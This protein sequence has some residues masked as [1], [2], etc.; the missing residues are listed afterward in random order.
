MSIDLGKPAD[1][2]HLHAI[3]MPGDLDFSMHLQ[4]GTWNNP[5]FAREVP[6][7][8]QLHPGS[9]AL[10][11]AL[12][13]NLVSFPSQ[14]PVL[15]KRPE[16]DMQWRMV[17]LF[18]LQGWS[19]ARIARRFGV[20]IHRIKK[21]LDEWAVRALALGYVQVIEPE[22]FAAC[23]QLDVEHGMDREYQIAANGPG[24]AVAAGAH[25]AFSWDAALTERLADVAAHASA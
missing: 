11:Q 22:G 12:R 25:T 6:I 15:L 19:S 10:R 16:P 14:I 7:S 20:P 4:D 8:T 24:R 9:G 2:A 1:A 3:F 5:A 23:C 17:L 21:S 13:S 18:F